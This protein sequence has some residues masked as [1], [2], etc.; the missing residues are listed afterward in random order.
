MYK[1]VLFFSFAI[2]IS[3]Y[4][5]DTINQYYF[6]NLK[7]QLESDNNTKKVKFEEKR[8]K[9]GKIASQTM[10]VKLKNDNKNRYWLIGKHYC[11]YKSGKLKHYENVDIRTKTYCDTTVGFDEDGSLK[12]IYFFNNKSKHSEVSKYLSLPFFRMRYFCYP[13]TFKTIIYNEDKT[14]IETSNMYN[15]K[16]QNAQYDFIMIKYLPGDS[17]ESEFKIIDGIRYRNGIKEE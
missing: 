11:Y 7:R 9:N 1:I 5:Q 12:W 13:D 17:I 14:R 15:Y 10:C 4:G 2:S 3:L 6:S 8:Y 16:N